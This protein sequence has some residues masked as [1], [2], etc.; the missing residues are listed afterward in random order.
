MFVLY[1]L[2]TQERLH[3]DWAFMWGMTA[4]TVKKLNDKISI[5]GM[6]Q[7]HFKCTEIVKKS[8]EDVTEKATNNS[9]AL[10]RRGNEKKLKARESCVCTAY[11][12]CWNDL[13]FKIQQ[14][15]AE[16]Q[17]QN[18]L[19]P[20]NILHSYEACR[21]TL[22]FVGDKT[23]AQL[24]EFVVKSPDKFSISIDKITTASNQISLVYICILYEAEK[25]C[26]SEHENWIV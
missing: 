8:G 9:A 19:N 6:C 13:S 21:S 7:S 26:E 25:P 11:T 1:S 3:T 14:V 17:Q 4:K 23:S 12:L 10:W 15:L 2:L 20:G 18:G 22:M 24:T 16:L 5:H